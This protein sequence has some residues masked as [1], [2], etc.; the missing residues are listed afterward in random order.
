MIQDY[1]KSHTRNG[2]KVSEYHKYVSDQKPSKGD[3]HNGDSHIKPGKR[4]NQKDMCET[5]RLK[6][7]HTISDLDLFMRHGG[8][9]QR[10]R[11]QSLAASTLP[12]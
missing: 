6:R 8:T 11:M 9:V 5:T 2:A 4:A 3:T 1:L 10:P 7:A 12:P